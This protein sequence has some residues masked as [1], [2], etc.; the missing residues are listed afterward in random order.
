MSRIFFTTNTLP[1]PGL[2]RFQFWR[3]NS[4]KTSALLETFCAFSKPHPHG[5]SV[6]MEN[7][8]SCITRACK[9]WTAVGRGYQMLE[10]CLRCLGTTWLLLTFCPV[11]CSLPY[12][13]KVSPSA[14]Q[15]KGFHSHCHIPPHH[16][17]LHD[18]EHSLNKFHLAVCHVTFCT[19]RSWC[20]L[21][22]VSW[23]IL[24]LVFG[25]FYII[26][27]SPSFIIFPNFLKLCRLAALKKG[28]CNHVTTAWYR[29]INGT[30]PVL[31]TSCSNVLG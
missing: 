27:V 21:P 11:F 1:L 7:R 19:S 30:D 8:Q 12:S 6:V 29:G 10:L 4:L 28:L 14:M 5:G 17:Y 3:V 16:S 18:T 15:S 31:F 26:A 25:V 20:M 2:L 22:L 13:Q 9:Q 23:P 24:E